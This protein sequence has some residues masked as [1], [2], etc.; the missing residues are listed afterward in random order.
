MFD[1]EDIST[2]RNA[3]RNALVKC[4][5]RAATAGDDA[6]QSYYNHEIAVFDR[7]FDVLDLAVQ[8]GRVQIIARVP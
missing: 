6:D 2:H 7:T 4:A 1:I 8:E 5:E 3:W